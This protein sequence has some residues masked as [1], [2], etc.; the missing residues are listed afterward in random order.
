MTPTRALLLGLY[1][2]LVLLLGGWA[3]TAATPDDW[4][5]LPRRTRP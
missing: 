3:F 5:S 2:I 4:G 1:V